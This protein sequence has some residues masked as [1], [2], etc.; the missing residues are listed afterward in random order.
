MPGT[1]AYQGMKYYAAEKLKT[2]SFDPLYINNATNAD[3]GENYFHLRRRRSC[4]NVS[5]LGAYA[6]VSNLALG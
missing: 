1:T 4:R 5:L 6:C 3:A 2:V